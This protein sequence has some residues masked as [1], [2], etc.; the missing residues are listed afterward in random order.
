MLQRASTRSAGFT[1]LGLLGFSLAA[2]FAE[3]AVA[4][5]TPDTMPPNSWLSVPNTK[6]RP[7]TPVYDQ[8]PGTWGVMGPRAVIGAWSSAA[9]DTKRNRLVL[10]GGGHGDYAGNEL[11]AF[12]I[13]TMTWSRLTDPTVNPA[14]DDSDLN[15]DGTPQSR[16]TYGGLAYLIKEDRFFALGGSIFSSGHGTCQRVW[17]YDFGAKQWTRETDEV[18]FFTG[19]DDFCKVDPVTGKVIFC[20]RDIGS[21]QH[22]RTYDFTTKVWTS[23]TPSQVDPMFRAV[24]L[25]AKRGKL[26][27]L[28]N[29]GV[30]AYDVRG[31]APVETWNTT[32][33]TS[34]VS[35]A[36]EAGFEYDPVSDKLVGWQEDKVHVLDPAT[37]VWTVHN[38]PGAPPPSG[39]GTWGRWSYV[40]SVNAFILVTGVDID[41]HFY[42]MPSTGSAA[43]SI[44]ADPA[45]QSTARGQTATFTVVAAGTGPLAYQ[46]QRNEAEIAGATSTSYTTPVTTE[47]DNGANYRVVISNS[48]GSA[49][50]HSAT[51][52]VTAS[53]DSPASSG[54][55]GDPHSPCGI[56]TAD[57]GDAAAFGM[58]MAMLVGLLLRRPHRPDAKRRDCNL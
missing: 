15:P 31:N 40:P 24:A 25:D 57:G 17:T 18:P 20:D 53:G 43:P 51:L 44:V 27:V 19:F 4:Q 32:G 54:G 22:I 14:N 41:V 28:T 58:A 5:N 1:L 2:L 11:Y 52:S 16:H 7:V 23:I 49:T 50:S 29:G 45:N 47:A 48:E 56:G 38:P 46:W 39:N 10:F 9:L 3:E 26:V 35:T 30:K 8:F 36:L 6:M 33:D 37:K 21:W 55:K 13:N 12:D 34:F 42:K